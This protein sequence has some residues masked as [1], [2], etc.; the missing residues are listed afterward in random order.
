[1]TRDNWTQWL[2]RTARGYALLLVFIW[3][4]LG[5]HRLVMRRRAW[6]LFP[7]LFFIGGG[8]GA[9]GIRYVSRSPAWGL[10]LLPY[11]ALLAHD[12]LTLWTWAWPRREAFADAL[13]RLDVRFEVSLHLAMGMALA[14]VLWLLEIHY[15]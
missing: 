11:F 5:L 4:P 14:V 13:R 12:T 7:A 1:M 15:G 3:L 9:A 2:W 8:I 10:F 6:W